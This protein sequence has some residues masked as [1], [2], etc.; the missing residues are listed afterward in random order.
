MFV[1][2]SD[3][4]REIFQRASVVA[5]LPVQLRK[6]QERL[7]GQS[8]MIESIKDLL[9][10]TDDATEVSKDI[11]TPNSKYV[12]HLIDVKLVPEPD[13]SELERKVRFEEAKIH[14]ENLAIS[15]RE[16][17]IRKLGGEEHEVNQMLT[18]QEKMVQKTT[19]E[20]QEENRRSYAKTKKELD[21]IK[22]K[23]TKVVEDRESTKK[24]ML[25][26]QK[27]K[28]RLEDEILEA[29]EGVS[30]KNK[31]ANELIGDCCRV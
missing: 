16:A 11:F 15:E 20:R 25:A 7:D 12:R 3:V 31:K 18:W 28:K 29:T 14:E 22:S 1:Y 21:D 19:G 6:I 27:E 13:T 5:N 4:V 2:F 23:M 30:T 9:V 26:H 24:S 8:S 10:V 17:D